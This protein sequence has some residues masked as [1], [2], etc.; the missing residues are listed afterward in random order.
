MKEHSGFVS[1]DAFIAHH[2]R[3][4]EGG[5]LNSKQVIRTYEILRQAKLRR[6]T[7]T[8]AEGRHNEAVCAHGLHG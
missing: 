8:L 3:R 1:H 2:R 7:A 4:A 6:R 5:D